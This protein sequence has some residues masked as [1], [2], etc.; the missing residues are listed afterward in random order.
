MSVGRKSNWQTSYTNTSLSNEINEQSFLKP[1][2]LD[3]VVII[4]LKMQVN[5]MRFVQSDIFTQR[6][7]RSLCIGLF[8]AS[9]FGFRRHHK[10][11][12]LVS[13]RVWRNVFLIS[14]SIFP[15][16]SRILGIVLEEFALNILKE[17][18]DHEFLIITD[19]HMCIS[20]LAGKLKLAGFVCW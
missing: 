20:H 1:W 17:S 13:S 16:I 2:F 10:L 5:V 9:L 14:G 7:L 15:L 19:H 4:R 12:R 3:I 8:L 18:S 6:T 11:R